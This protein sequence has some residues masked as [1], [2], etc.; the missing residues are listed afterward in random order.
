MSLEE[1][2]EER[3]EVAHPQQPHCATV[4]VLDTSGSMS[5][6]KIRQL[7]D[8]IGFFVEDVA[9]D[10]LARKRVDLAVVTFGGSV[11]VSHDFSSIDD[12]DAPV[13]RADGG[14]PMGEAILRAVDMVKSRKES[15]R[16]LG[17]DYFRPWIFLITDGEPTDMKPGDE[18]WERAIGAIS[19]GEKNREFLFFVVGVEPADMQI[20]SKI[21]PAERPPLHLRPGRFRE[22]FMWLSRSQQK[23]SASRVGDQVALEDP[24]GPQGWAQIETI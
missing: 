13:L 9:A 24:T 23:V 3:I 22:M 16:E 14:T 18:L 10:D 8:G 1:S 20:L 19:E 12:F 4:L 7:N 6:D 15:Y 2:L 17:T 5:G 21:A 11:D